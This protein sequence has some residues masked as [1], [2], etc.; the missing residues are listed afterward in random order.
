MADQ[1]QISM[2]AVEARVLELSA[3]RFG[4]KSI[5]LVTGLPED[6][7]RTAREAAIRYVQVA[8]RV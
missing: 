7:V 2:S 1:V 5:A 6:E 4:V 8:R 3:R